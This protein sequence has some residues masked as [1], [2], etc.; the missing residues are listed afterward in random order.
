MLR[1]V[2]RVLAACLFVIAFAAAGAD[3]PATIT[4]D[5]P[6]DGSVFPPEITPPTFLWRDTQGGATSWIIEVA[7]A[8]RSPAIRVRSAGERMRT[9]EID[10][11]AVAPSNELPKLTPEQAAAHTWTPDA[12]TW[13]AIKKR[14]VESPATIAITGVIDGSP[15]SRGVVKIATSKDPVGAPIFYRDVPLMPNQSEKGVVKPLPSSAIH[16]IKWR[17][18]YIGEPKSQVV[19]EQ[20][21]TCANCHS[22]SRD[23]KTLGLDV[24]GPQNDRGLYALVPVAK[25][26]TIRNQD[27]IKWPTVRGPKVE[28]LRA[29]FMSQVSP[30]GRYV[31]TT[32][33]DPEASKREGGRT[34]EDKYYNANFMDY[35]FL[36]VFYPTRGMLAWYDRETKRL[37]PLPGA[38]DPRYVQT[39]GV[40]SPD[41]KYI[42]FARAEAKSPY[43]P[44]V[45][46][47]MYANDPNETQIQYDLY[48]MP[49]N[50]GKGGRPEGIVGASENGMS[51]NFPKVSPDGRWIV[52]VRCRNGQLM[53]PDS[54]LYMVPFQGGK[55]RL[56]KCNTRLMN[57]WHTF[58][59]NGR[60]LAFS[61][62]SRSPY[63]QMYLTHLDEDGN[64][65]PPILVDNSTAANRAV[66]LPE[67]VNIAPSGMER[68][69]APATEFYKLFN[70]AIETM[71][72]NRFDEAVPQW[73]KA[74][75][76]NPED[77]KAH[78]NLGYSMFERGELEKAI[79]EYRRACELDPED[80]VVHANLALALA[81]TGKL[82]EAVDHYAKALGLNPGNPMVEADLGVALFENGKAAEAIEH[83]KKAVEIDP[84]NAEA[85]SK[86]GSILAK[87]GQPKEAVA[88]LEKAVA[89]SPDSVEFQFNLG[90]V[91]GQMGS[92]AEAVPHMEKA[93]ELS[94]G[95][96]W[97]SLSM[98][99]AAY[100]Q[101]GRPADAVQ[102]TRRA[103]DV[104]VRENN[105]EV[106]RNLRAA[107][108]RY[109]RGKSEAR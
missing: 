48:R 22:F 45:P 107:I 55:D 108:E 81:Q 49:F 26:M 100:F 18:R 1:G 37:Q 20:P 21:A 69:E 62:K 52:F 73:R 11:E 38:N 79:E 68:I 101:S 92:Y 99:G 19:M 78:F 47:A 36:Q 42:V 23:G 39:D 64:D 24:D 6:I 98:L 46:L 85:R 104:A 2:V 102:A 13:T 7:F 14:S 28:R 59:P 82:D 80:A 93:V 41:G 4:V 90:Y 66:N 51:N 88:H 50:D 17:L 96:E 35:R 106:A 86:L 44:G 53:R 27:V 89:L 30:D 63:T 74:L 34:L 29:A 95:K 40:W 67:F 70:I 43:P 94:G 32:I 15:V 75:E 72:K 5:Y 33:D 57:S 109:E 58:S 60:W 10:P 83:L 105:E 16:L 56:M 65:T 8:D 87:T 84:E 91:L 61:S 76:L 77:S 3:R 103:L 9:G 12:E 31:L 54:K 97:Q 25:Q 71:K